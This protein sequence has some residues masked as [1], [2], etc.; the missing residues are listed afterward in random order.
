VSITFKEL[1]NFAF[2]TLPYPAAVQYSIPFRMYRLTRHAGQ[3]KI[4]A[5]NYE[6]KAING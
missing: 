2:L 3:Q 4:V 5:V 1:D 6:W